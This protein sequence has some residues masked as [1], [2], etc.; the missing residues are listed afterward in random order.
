MSEHTHSGRFIRSSRRHPCP[1]CGRVKDSDC[2]WTQDEEQVF[3]HH[4]REDLYP[5]AR[6]GD[7]A[8]TGNT[9]DGRCAHFVRHRERNNRPHRRTIVTPS[10]KGFSDP[11]PDQKQAKPKRPSV[12]QL[13]LARCTPIDP[14][15]FIEDGCIRT[16][17][18]VENC[19]LVCTW[20]H[21]DF[22]YVER[23]DQ[24]DGDK[25]FVPH[26]HNGICWENVSG[27]K[28]WKVY[29][30]TWDTSIRG[31]W[32]IEFEGEKC[33]EIAES[34]GYVA[35]SQPGH[36][37]SVGL[38]VDRYS[39][40]V[41]LGCAGIIYVA[42]N[43]EAGDQKAER[44][45]EAAAQVSLP[46][47][48]I[49]AAAISPGIKSKGSI[50]DV[51]DP[52]DFIAA[53]IQKAQEELLQPAKGR[54]WKEREQLQEEAMRL[55]GKNPDGSMVCPPQDRY[56]ELRAFAKDLGL[57]L[58]PDDIR[59][60]VHEA[61]ALL[62]GA[63]EM[64][65][66]EQEITA[67]EETWLWQGVL[68][69]ADSNMLIS[70]PK[71]GKTTL[72]IAMIAAWFHGAQS[73]LGQP[74]VGTCPPVVIVGPDMPRIRWMK[75]L[76]RFGLAEQTA[77][78]KWKLLGPVKGLFSKSEAI[79]LDDAGLARIA[80]LASAYPGALFIFDSYT[81]LTSK[82]GYKEA[83]SRFAGPAE[84]VQEVCA[85]HSI[86]MVVLHHAGHS[87]QGEGA[88]AASRG[89]TALPAA[90]SQVINMAWF[91]RNESK[92]DKRVL[93]E[94]EGREED[95]Q[96]L[97]LQNNGGWTLE[98]DASEQLEALFK[99]EQEDKLSDAKADVLELCRERWK[100]HFKR[101]T[102]KDV[103]EKCDGFKTKDG[104]K[105][106]KALRALRSLEGMGLL[107][108]KAETTE[109]GTEIA[110]KPTE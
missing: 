61:R 42:D 24:P 53:A 102:R 9:K 78:G 38:I 5:G 29:R 47:V 32:V 58:Y 74:L 28:P 39:E 75:L 86:T 19:Q 84:D 54:L 52:G 25:T 18:G 3:C 45:K 35:I 17:R 8:F 15:P 6:V 64:L 85:P 93:L 10:S 106:R 2:S 99:Q 12:T 108:S 109:N 89:S 96:L 72:L 37:H 44:C 101:T 110:F 21:S 82:L 23:W 36:I 73:Y 63:V 30:R 49:R 105:D 70:L 27:D 50:D 90:F 65:T 94:T 43:D 51:D 107:E 62:A 31:L 97:I 91:K 103:I 98:G 76:N 1:I 80:D 55:M 66:P 83:D 11:K 26:H 4:A 34:A 20:T 57:H 95:L 79:Q 56:V 46:F 77:G 81:K 41:E 14:T 88:V 40:L 33:T 60:V 68:L 16:I 7:Y 71:V 22:Q 48:A 13:E 87:R 100:D 104:N 92:T 69:K 67:P 59:R